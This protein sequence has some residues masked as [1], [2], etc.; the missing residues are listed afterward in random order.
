[1]HVGDEARSHP[2][3]ILTVLQIN[4]RRRGSAIVCAPFNNHHGKKATDMMAAP[5]C[6][7]C[8]LERTLVSIQ[9]TRNRH[10]MRQY[11]CPK[12]RSAF[13]LVVPRPS[14]ESDD[15]VFDTPALRAGTG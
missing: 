10:D 5:I 12:C 8:N 13:R 15:V 7:N 6:I 1:M 4:R 2:A 11:E 9:P 3:R 14:L